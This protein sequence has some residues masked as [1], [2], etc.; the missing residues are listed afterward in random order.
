MNKRTEDMVGLATEAFARHQLIQRNENRWRIARL[1][2][3]RAMSVY[4]TEIASLWSGGL[5]VGGDIDDCV[6]ARYLDS[7][8]P[9]ARVRWIGE[10]QD[11]DWY[12]WQKARIGM[13]DNGKVTT[14]GRGRNAGPNARVIYAWAAARRLCQLLDRSP[15][16]PG[17]R[18]DLKGIDHGECCLRKHEDG[19]VDM[20]VGWDGWFRQTCLPQEAAIRMARFL[21]EPKRNK[22]NG[23]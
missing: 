7:P 20:S 14:E 11:L 8:D 5:Y 3:G 19:S 22:E 10:C 2:N 18:L 4:A 23:Q 21:L 15:E 12:V 17:D 16:K 6:F 9:I 13:S 1:D